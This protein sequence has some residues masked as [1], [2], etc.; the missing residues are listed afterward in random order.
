MTWGGTSISECRVP[1]PYLS[2]PYHSTSSA[3]IIIKEDLNQ[4]KRSTAS[5]LPGTPAA[6][7]LIPTS[8]ITSHY[9]DPG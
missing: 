2:L 3:L 7:T 1:T 6:L 4:K 5:Q 9:S 8:A